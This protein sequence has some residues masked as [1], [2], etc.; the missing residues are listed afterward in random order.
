MNIFT[1][2]PLN[3]LFIDQQ[4]EVK[5]LSSSF[6]SMNTRLDLKKTVTL[7]RGCCGISQ[8]SKE[9]KKREPTIVNVVVSF[10]LSASFALAYGSS[11]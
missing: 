9:K 11:V 5:A 6:R 2:S 8:S 10:K 7:L 1:T 3:L 4:S